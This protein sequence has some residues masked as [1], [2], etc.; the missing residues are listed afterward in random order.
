M[1]TEGSGGH[2]RLALQIV[3]SG[4]AMYGQLGKLPSWVMPWP[5]AAELGQGL[6]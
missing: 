5:Y 6:L 1:W 3:R 2:G 4:P